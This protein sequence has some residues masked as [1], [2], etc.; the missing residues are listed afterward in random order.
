MH[1]GGG[2]GNMTV[3]LNRR[4]YLLLSPKSRLDS[5]FHD[6]HCLCELIGIKSS[7]SCFSNLICS[8]KQMSLI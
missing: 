4:L 7:T 6:L 8:F 3:F 2:G 1:V 5:V